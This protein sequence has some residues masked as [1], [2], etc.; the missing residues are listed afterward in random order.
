[1]LSGSAEPLDLDVQAIIAEDLSP[2]AQSRILAQVAR[3][4]LAAAEATNRVALGYV[5][6]HTTTVDG[7]AGADESR[8]RPDGEIVYAF[9]LVQDLFA[10]IAHELESFAPVRSGRYLHAFLFF[11]DGVLASL[12]GEAPE[13]REFVFMSAVPYAGKIEGEHRA[14]ESPQAPNGVFE[15]V[16]VLAQHAFPGADV[17]FSYRSPFT[18]I[19]G[20]KDT[21][22]ITIRLG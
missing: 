2:D 3:D 13:G 4:E 7:A 11:V 17:A 5:P 19:T 22:A 20:V 15:A 8:V 10:W 9:D 14:P 6:G 18:P 16:A 1:M 12:D 21:P